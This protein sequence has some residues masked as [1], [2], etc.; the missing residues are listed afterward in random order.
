MAPQCITV[1]GTT[2]YDGKWHYMPPYITLS[3]DLTAYPGFDVNKRCCSVTVA[4][5]STCWNLMHVSDS[6]C[7]IAASIIFLASAAAKI[8]VSMESN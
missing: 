2:I 8:S 5:V 7:L 4:L 1:E 3:H 6:Q